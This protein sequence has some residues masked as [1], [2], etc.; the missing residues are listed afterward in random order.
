M[1]YGMK[2]QLCDGFKHGYRKLS[3]V[4]CD[5]DGG[6]KE[7]EKLLAVFGLI[8][9]SKH[10]NSETYPKCWMAEEMIKNAF[11]MLTLNR[12]KDLKVRQKKVVK[13]SWCWPLSKRAGL[14]IGFPR[15]TDVYRV[16]IGG[17]TRKHTL[18]S[19]K[20]WEVL[21]VRSVRERRGPID[22][23]GVMVDCLLPT[24]TY[25]SILCETNIDVNAR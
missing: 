13:E 16:P 9:P 21:R 22:V 20:E 14:R 19:E 12:C 25:L 18:C 23:I 11:H 1:W 7:A 3:N 6:Q 15:V 2:Q 24:T 5:Q 4:P 17:K 8:K 10:S